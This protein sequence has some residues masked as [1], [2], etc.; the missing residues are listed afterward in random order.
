MT[1]ASGDTIIVS[2]GNVGLNPQTEMEILIPL[3][4]GM[5][6]PLG[7]EKPLP[8]QRRHKH[9]GSVNRIV[10]KIYIIS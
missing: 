8:L 1:V 6:L 7:L 5:L 2:S 3:A 9:L 4:V 10:N